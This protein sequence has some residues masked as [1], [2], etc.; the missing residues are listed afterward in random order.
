MGQ[1]WLRSTTAFAFA[2][3]PRS[4][5]RPSATADFATTRKPSG[6][7][8]IVLPD[9]VADEILDAFVTQAVLPSSK[10]SW[11]VMWDRVVALDANTLS[12][13]M[14]FLTYALKRPARGFVKQSVPRFPD[15]F[16]HRVNLLVASPRRY[17]QDCPTEVGQEAVSCN[18]LAPLSASSVK[19]LIA[20]NFDVQL[21]PLF[22]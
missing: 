8:Q 2:M 17:P 15:F 14:E 1:L 5:A 11:G 21:D 7:G 3:R 20:V 19:V 12:R 10:K 22:Q 9:A 18:V 4:R 16:N 6:A 13:Q